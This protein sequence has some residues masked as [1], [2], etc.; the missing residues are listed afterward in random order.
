MNC[1]EVRRC[2][3]PYLDSELDPATTFSIGEHLAGCEACRRRFEAELRVDQK[4]AR[5][6]QAEGVTDETWARV[7]RP[8]RQSPA[9]PI[10]RAMLVAVSLA[11]SLLLLLAAG[12]W[13]G[14]PATGD[15]S[16]W[17]QELFNASHGSAG[18][19]LPGSP[20][21]PGASL[22]MTPFSD[23]SLVLPRDRMLGHEIRFVQLQSK[24]E[25][26]GASIVRLRLSCCG[27]PVLLVLARRG[28][29]ERLAGLTS[30]PL[31]ETQAVT[32]DRGVNY[33]YRYV[34]G[35][36]VVALSRHPVAELLHAVR[37]QQS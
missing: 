25:P 29:V 1:R 15:S 17:V 19:E 31:A 2:L 10:R 37:V 12:L 32:L 3:S 6:L 35:Y 34:G 33:Q 30:N 20:M 21:Q 26:S 5:A 8:L 9:A 27:E 36:V 18:A 24:P 13:F 7:V 16:P 14:A 23:V 11:A 28:Q 4:I 22:P